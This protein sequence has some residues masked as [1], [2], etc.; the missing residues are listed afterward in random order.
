MAVNDQ[1]YGTPPVPTASSPTTSM[2]SSGKQ[3]SQRKSI[4]VVTIVDENIMRGHESTNHNKVPATTTC[5]SVPVSPPRSSSA[6]LSVSTSLSG[7]VDYGL[8]GCRIT[9]DHSTSTL[10]PQQQPSPQHPKQ[11]H[12]HLYSGGDVSPNRRTSPIAPTAYEERHI[13]AISS[14]AAGTPPPSFCPFLPRALQPKEHIKFLPYM[15]Q[16][17]HN[18]NSSRGAMSSSLTS[19]DASSTTHNSSFSFQP[20]GETPMYGGVEPKGAPTAVSAQGVISKAG[21]KEAFMKMMHATY[22]PTSQQPF[23]Q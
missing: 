13:S 4:P 16:H 2:A 22:H 19:F 12:H 20:G 7:K 8:P 1:R 15:S 10:V 23:V 11:H 21:G 5:T 3:H 18:N 9:W 6:R 14:N 17:M